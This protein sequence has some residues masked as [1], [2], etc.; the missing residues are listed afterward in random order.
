M[1]Y[2]VKLLTFAIFCY[3]CNSISTDEKL[4]TKPVSD[5]VQKVKVAAKEQSVVKIEV[6]E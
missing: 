1:K 2:I 4:T 5:S 6:L 3:S